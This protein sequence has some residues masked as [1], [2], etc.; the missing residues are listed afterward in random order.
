MTDNTES[1]TLAEWNGIKIG[2]LV[3]F[4]GGR[5]SPPGVATVLELRAQ[6]GLAPDAE[7]VIAKIE[8]ET[9]RVREVSAA[10]LK[11]VR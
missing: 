11:P 6:V 9:G 10:A 5:P 3:R 7:T 1:R 2:D 8:D 4:V